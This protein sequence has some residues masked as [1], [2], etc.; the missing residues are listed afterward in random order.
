MMSV[1]IQ[2]V[3]EVEKFITNTSKLYKR[4]KESVVCDLIANGYD[5]SGDITGEDISRAEDPLHH[6]GFP[7]K[8]SPA[9]ERV[10]PT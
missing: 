4:S 8:D 2:I 6:G 10:N 7:A 9:H 1:N 5:P 3:G